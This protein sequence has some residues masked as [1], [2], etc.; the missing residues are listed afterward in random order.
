MLSLKNIAAD[1]PP[2]QKKRQVVDS[3]FL[4]LLGFT[5]LGAG[6]V[7]VQFGFGRVWQ[8]VIETALF[9]LV[10]SPKVICGI[11]IAATM[12]L[13]LPRDRVS[14][15]IGEKSG[16]RGLALASLAGAVIP[17]GPMM[18]FLMASGFAVAGAD[19][20]AVIAFISGWALLGLNRTLIWELSFLASD[21]VLWRYALSLP[22]PVL[23][24]VTVRWFWPRRVVT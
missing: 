21:L 3:G 13:L 24:G 7:A 22:F 10:L 9:I 8:I 12:P 14:Q 19:I 23:L 6:A 16:I 11:F 15:W 1:P 4:I 20:G 18:I 17:G 5:V 2:V